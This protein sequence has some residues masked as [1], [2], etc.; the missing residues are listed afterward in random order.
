MKSKEHAT[1]VGRY[2]LAR[3]QEPSSIK[4]LIMA[5]TAFGWYQLDG[6]SSGENVAQLG[7]LVVGAI[8]AA[9]PQ[10]V[11]YSDKGSV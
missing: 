2:L 9:L 6:A 4:G 3:L 8:N 5:G 11:L 10:K 1:R 7:L